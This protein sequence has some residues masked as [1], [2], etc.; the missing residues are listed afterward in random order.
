MS[1][2]FQENKTVFISGLAPSIADSELFKKVTE[3]TDQ[4]NVQNVHINVD[5][6]NYDTFIGY[7]NLTS[8]EAA[9]EVI[10]KMNGLIFKDK[11]I[12]MSWSIK[13][14]KM[15]TE[16]ESNLFVKGIKRDVSQHELQEVFAQYGEILS[17]KLSSNEK[18][19]SNGFGY[20]KFVD[21]ESAEKA[22][23]AKE[24]IKA[25]IGDE[26]FDIC[27]YVKQPTA[28]RTNLYIANVDKNI[29]EEQFV[30]YFETFGNIRLD[31]NG[32][33]LYEYVFVE[34]YNKYRGYV[35]YADAV[36]AEK[37]L[38]APKANVLGEGELI[39]AYYKTK[40]ERKR[41]YKQME[42]ER[43]NVYMGKYKEFN[44]Y[45]NT[46]QPVANEQE[47]KEKLEGCGS[48]FSLKVKYYNHEPTGVVYV[49]FTDAESTQKAIEKCRGLGWDCNKLISRAERMQQNYQYQFSPSYMYPINYF[50]YLQLFPHIFRG[51]WDGKPK[52]MNQKPKGT[53]GQKRQDQ[54]VSKQVEPKQAPVEPVVEQTKVVTDDMKNDLG[55]KLYDHILSMGYEEELTGRITGV[56]LD[57]LEYDQLKDKIDNNKTELNKII[58]EVKQTL[59]TMGAGNN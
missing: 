24:E 54:K 15:R 17:V 1:T 35:N 59:E 53:K 28:A 55:D 58:E 11:K 5:Q 18:N 26:K 8:H 7:I 37:A 31:S 22:I 20:V 25:K 41:E 9:K 30:K 6:H 2:E 23:L 12:N 46:K 4:K 49:C 33:K 21:I 56:L 51:Q 34:K 3:F 19:Q 48:I 50:Q 32:K 45:V 40:A 16:N 10:S 57:S 52:G 42:L 13:D 36:D 43:K 44:L 14:Y 47:V 38:T 29:N 39:V 27:K